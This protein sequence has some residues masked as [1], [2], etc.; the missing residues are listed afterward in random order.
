MNVRAL[1]ADYGIDLDDIRWYLAHRLALRAQELLEEDRG[2]LVRWIWSGELEAE[3]Y[4]NAERFLAD[5]Q[6]GIDRR[7]TD[8][9]RVREIYAEAAALKKDRPDR[10]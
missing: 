7:L 2:E 1:L 5:L 3:L 9:P 10:S 8:E 4:D 6:D